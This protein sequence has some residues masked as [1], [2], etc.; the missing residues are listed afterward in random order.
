MSW[1]FCQRLPSPTKVVYDSHPQYPTFAATFSLLLAS[2]SSTWA[3]STAGA[4][5]I[6]LGYAAVAAPPA[7]TPTAVPGLTLLGIGI[8]GG[9]FAAI[10]W[11]NRHKGGFNRL[12][13]VALMSGA[14]L[15]SVA[16]GDSLVNVVRAAG[17]YEFSSAT[18]GTVADTQVAYADPAPM[19]TVTNTSGGRIK[20]TSNGNASETGTC[21]VNAEL[22]PGASCTTQAFACTPP[23][24]VVQEIMILAAPTFTCDYSTI[25]T[26]YPQSN[27]SA[28]GGTL[29]VNPPV[30]DAAPSFDIN[31]VTTAS[32]FT[33]NATQ[34]AYASNGM[35]SN[36]NDLISGIFTVIATAPAGY[37]FGASLSSTTTWDL[38][39]S[40]G[41]PE[42]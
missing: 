9:L 37:G 17:P 24:P 31:G 4:C 35:I 34:A 16:G 28:S 8:L 10:T 7:V 11:R 23:P 12:M 13:S 5:E 20:I 41:V 22:A 27:T 6:A 15:L 38:P 1:P 18:G 14:A 30:L 21:T 40:C 42:M 29:T 39:F 3:Q 26:T 25:L 2:S 32:T 33:R 19:L 36:T